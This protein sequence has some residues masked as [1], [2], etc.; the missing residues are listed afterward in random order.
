MSNLT[1]SHK[2]L[3]ITVILALIISLILPVSIMMNPVFDT[4]S[5]HSPLDFISLAAAPRLNLTYHTLSDT[6]VHPVTSDSFIAGDHVIITAVW[7]DYQVNGSRLEI[8]A[9]AIPATL[10][11][12]LDT[13]TIEIDSRYLGNNATCIINATT[14]LTNGTVFFKTFEN[15][16]I[17]NFFV[18]IISVISPN[19]NEKWT[20][21]NNITWTAS[22]NNEADL[23]RYDVLLSSDNGTI[24]VTLASSITTTWFE[25]DCSA[26]DKL[27]TYLVEVRVTDG[28]Y[29]SSD[30]SDSPF[31]AGEIVHTTTTATTTTTTDSLDARLTAFLIILVVSCSLIAMVVYYAARK[32]F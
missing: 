3:Q 25:W 16:Y 29:F 18:P 27:D 1:N 26:L 4:E 17:G 13:N 24:F 20:G 15:V 22:D 23:L 5:N 19:G 9:P 14:W 12:E 2:R 6:T 8:I 10:I 21:I 7:T 31:T 28:I 11:Q 32:W 30:R